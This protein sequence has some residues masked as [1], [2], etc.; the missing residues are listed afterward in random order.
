M[1]SPLTLIP[2]TLQ[3]EFLPLLELQQHRQPLPL[4]SASCVPRNALELEHIVAPTLRA[5]FQILASTLVLLHRNLL[6]R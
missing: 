1:S 4:L 3:Q 2:T 5:E 6:D